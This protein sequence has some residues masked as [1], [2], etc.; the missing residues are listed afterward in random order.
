MKKHDKGK[1]SLM[2][3][4]GSMQIQKKGSKSNNFHFVGNMDSSRRIAQNVIL[5]SKRKLSLMLMYFQSNLT[6]VPHNTCWI[7]S[8]CTTRVSNTRL[9]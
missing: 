2:T 3:N 8:K 9:K 5:G 7:G 6:E 4:D 1:G